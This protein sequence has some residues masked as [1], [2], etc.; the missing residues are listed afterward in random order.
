LILLGFPDVE[1]RKSAPFQE[2]L[3][4]FAAEHARFQEDL[5]FLA[6][7]ERE[8]QRGEGQDG[9]R[10]GIENRNVKTEK[11][12]ARRALHLWRKGR[13]GAHPRLGSWG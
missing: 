2:D 8:A 9:A 3:R 11:E 4:F 10:V 5:R 13:F 7:G 12:C 6:F 1:G